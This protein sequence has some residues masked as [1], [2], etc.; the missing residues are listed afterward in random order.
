[1]P[2]R[3]LDFDLSL[4]FSDRAFIHSCWLPPLGRFWSRPF[5]VSLLFLSL[6]RSLFLHLR[7]SHL[8]LQWF[9]CVSLLMN[10]RHLLPSAKKKAEKTEK[11]RQ[12]LYEYRQ[13]NRN[14]IQF[15]LVLSISFV[16][17]LLTFFS[18]HPTLIIILVSAWRAWNN[19]YA[20]FSWNGIERNGTNPNPKRCQSL[21]WRSIRLATWWEMQTTTNTTT[22]ISIYVSIKTALCFFN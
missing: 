12:Q 6:S 22:I 2:S 18:I 19:F 11:K 17:F 8:L 5:P 16:V 15:M 20:P 1:M 14:Q 9:V 13:T 10:R 3:W 21:I 7:V 4:P